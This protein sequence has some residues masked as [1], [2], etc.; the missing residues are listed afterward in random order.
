MARQH[1]TKD[2]LQGRVNELRALRD[3]IR[4][5]LHLAGMDLRDEWKAIEQRLPDPVR[6]LEQI[7]EATGHTLEQLTAE[8]RR[9]RARLRDDAQG[10]LAQIMSRDVA[11]CAPGDSL[12]QALITMWDRDVGCLPVVD[13]HGR[14]VGMITDRDAAIAAATRGQ[15]M[16]DISVESAMAKDVVA[17]APWDKVEVGLSRMRAAKIR[18]VPVIAE[19]GALTGMVTLGDIA[20]AARKGSD[21]KE[22]SSVFATITDPY[23]SGTE[24]VN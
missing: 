12:A 9:F 19:D 2:E 1:P 13:R 11:T 22:I 20:R 3:E 21:S 10:T 14:V 5:D 15:R 7:R 16:D 23:A 18:R 4:L 8:L 17:C 6:A 24:R